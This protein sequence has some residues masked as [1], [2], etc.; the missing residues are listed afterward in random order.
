MVPEIIKD[1]PPDLYTVKKP[2]LNKVKVLN[3]VWRLFKGRE[4]QFIIFAIIRL[5]FWCLLAA[6][7][8]VIVH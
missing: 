5:K 7:F 6:S 2:G 1:P 4:S 8:S 3:Y